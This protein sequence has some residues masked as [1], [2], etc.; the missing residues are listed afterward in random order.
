[1]TFA[2]CVH[3]TPIGATGLVRESGVI[4]GW[5]GMS[6]GERIDKLAEL[7]KLARL[8]AESH[9]TYSVIAE[10]ATGPL[11][12]PLGGLPVAVKENIDVVGLPVLIETA[13]D[14]QSPAEIDA[15]IIAT[16]RGAGATFVGKTTSFEVAFAPAGGGNLGPALNPM[17]PSRIAGGSSGASAATVARGTVRVSIAT[18]TSGST[19]VPASFC[20]VVGYRATVG[21]Y[22]T[23]GVRRHSWTRDAIGIHAHSAL[24][25]GMI[26]EL[27][28]LERDEPGTGAAGLVLGVVRARF[29]DLDG[30]VERVMDDTVDRLVRAGVRLVDVDIPPDSEL[31][32][33]PGIEIVLWEAQRLITARAA[34]AE[35][36]RTP[37]L[38]QLIDASIGDDLKELLSIIRQ[39]P[40]D[41]RTYAAAHHSRARL[42]RTYSQLFDEMGVDALLYPTCPIVAP[43][44]G[45]E[46]VTLGHEDVPLRAVLVRNTAP[47]SVAGLPMMS[48]PAGRSSEG[49]PV[50]VCLEALP[51]SD[52]ALLRLGQCLQE[53]LT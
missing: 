45:A 14:R 20:G 40:V 18:D 3:E 32:G 16:L 22:P 46:V 1:M 13:F 2:T 7:D 5:T 9:R 17:D 10:A 12:A 41:S 31:S 48:V 23:D 27:L 44:L 39:R 49:L 36:G 51:W 24:D 33:V 26:D 43:K 15:A 4:S 53:V 34:T 38:S 28:S 30:E 47:G 35:E 29:Q 42:R 8:E 21:R 37:T 11:V 25:I 52:R 50:G 6:V 19:L